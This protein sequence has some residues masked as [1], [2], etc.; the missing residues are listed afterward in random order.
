MPGV[1]ERYWTMIVVD[2]DTGAELWRAFNTDL[3]P[4]G[5]LLTSPQG[6]RYWAVRQTVLAEDDSTFTMLARRARA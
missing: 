1:G 3:I 6:E 2:V 4:P 5:V